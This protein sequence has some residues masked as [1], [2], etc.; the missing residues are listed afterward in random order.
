MKRWKPYSAFAAAVI[1][2]L[3]LAGCGG[4]GNADENI[5]GYDWR[6]TGIVAGSGVIIHDGNSMDVLVTVGADS[7]AFYWDEPVKILLD[8]VAFP[9]RIPNAGQRF[10]A[11]SFDDMDGDGES[12][13]RISFLDESGDITE[14]VWLWDP[15]ERC[16]IY[17]EDLST[18]PTGYESRSG[19]SL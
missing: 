6:T 17:R 10:N 4:L 9:M 16:Y 11:I 3:S 15:A 14:L 12:D 1:L 2:C 13:V 7:A 8:S 19:I 18:V 5:A